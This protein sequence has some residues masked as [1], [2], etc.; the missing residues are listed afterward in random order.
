MVVNKCINFKIY[1][2]I[3]PYIQSMKNIKI[4][5]T[6]FYQGFQPS[7]NPF[8]NILKDRF[9]VELDSDS[10]D[11][12]FYSCYGYDFLHYNCPRIFYTGENLRPDF[13]LCDY[14]IGFDHFEFEDRYLRFPNYALFE[15]QFEKLTEIKNDGIEDKDYFCN[16]IYSNNQANP[17]RDQF[18]HSLNEYKK[19]SSPGKHLNNVNIEIGGRY[20]SDWM[21][22]KIDFQSK[23]KFTIAFE[24]SSSPGYTTE[25]IMHAFLAGTIPIYWGNPKVNLDF[26]PEAFINY[27]DFNNLQELKSEVIRVDQDKELYEEIMKKPVFRNNMMPENLKKERLI[28]FLQSILNQN[29]ESA[30]RRPRYGTTIKYES[31]LKEMIR[32]KNSFKWKKLFR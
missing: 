2:F 29:L 12:L 11:F 17:I 15:G 19:I 4:W 32:K 5:F 14:A 9:S 20:A 28:E 16:F 18:F 31:R 22:S 21:F 8:I 30:F 27:H 10:P 26:N 13:N 24:N 7:D 1:I 25:K 3:S 6:D 23:C